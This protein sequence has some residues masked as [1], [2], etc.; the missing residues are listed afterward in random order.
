MFTPDGRRDNGIQKYLVSKEVVIVH[1]HTASYGISF[2]MADL[3]SLRP[4]ARNWA[5]CWSYL[6][7]AVQVRT[8]KH[9]RFYREQL[10]APPPNAGPVP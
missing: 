10:G 4:I 1:Y 2:D 5:S 7:L 3:T 8:T 9:Y 6:L